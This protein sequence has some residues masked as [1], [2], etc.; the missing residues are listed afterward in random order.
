[1]K[2]PEIIELMLIA[3]IAWTVLTGCTSHTKYR[4]TDGTRT[5]TFERTTIIGSSNATE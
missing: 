5:T 2:L 1:M 3:A 4:T